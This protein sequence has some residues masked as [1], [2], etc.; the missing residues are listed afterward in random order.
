MG[1]SSRISISDLGKKSHLF[2]PLPKFSRSKF[3]VGVEG[4]VLLNII[5]NLRWDRIFDRALS[6]VMPMR[7]FD[8][9]YT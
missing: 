5:A 6:L 3:L 2:G 9:F 7:K 1:P 8:S 4:I